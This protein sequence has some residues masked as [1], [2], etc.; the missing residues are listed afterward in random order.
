MPRVIV[1]GAGI[2][3]V[4]CAR[5][6]VSA[7]VTVSIRE[8]AEHVGGRMTSPRI[9]GRYV[10]L[11]ASYFTASDPDF[12]ALADDWCARGLARRWTDRFPN[13]T[14]A[15]LSEPK[16]G[17]WRYATP[18]GLRSLVAD[19]ADAKPQLK[20][21]LGSPVSIV[22]SGPSG[23]S[24]DGE[25]ADAVVLTMPDPQ[26]KRILGFDLTELQQAI[27]NRAWQPVLALFAIYRHRGWED[28]EGAFVNDNPTLSWIADDGARRGDGAP[29][30]VAHSTPEFATRHLAAPQEATSLL[31]TAVDRLLHAG[32]PSLAKVHRFT[33]AKPVDSREEQYFYG[34]DRIGLAGDG[35]GKA[36]VETAW[37]SGRALGRR[38]AAEL[39]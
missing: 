38:I 30:L 5:E 28:F 23:P 3:G 33:Y 4:A 39:L 37:L 20:P 15:G 24:V 14:P 32:Q 31:V 16:A 2:A 22:E 7:G 34:K 21:V 17:P 19:I 10:D 18:A 13:L 6:L 9:E 29:V 35:W 26:A 11:G 1:I 12:A 27:T 25:P 36:K 8:R